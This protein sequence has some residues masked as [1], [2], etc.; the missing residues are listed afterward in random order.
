MERLDAAK[1]SICIGIYDFTA[2]YIRDALIGAM[3]RGVVVELMLDLSGAKEQILFDS[4]TELGAATLRAPSCDSPRAKYF[5]VVHQ[6][7]IVID[8][9]WVLVQ[10]GNYSDNSIPINDPAANW[11][12]FKTGNRDTGIAIESKKIAAFFAK[13]LAADRK[14]VIDA[15][16]APKAIASLKAMRQD[17]A[18]F[19]AKPKKAPTTKFKP[20][21]FAAKNVVV[22]PVLT[23]DNYLPTMEALL[24]GATRSVRI[25]QQ[26]IWSWQSK[27]QVLIQALARAQAKHPKLV[28][29][30]V[31]GKAFKDEDEKK[32]DKALDRLQQDLGLNRTEHVRFINQ[33]MFTHCHNKMILID[34]AIAVIS[35]QN[36]SDTAVD[37]NREAGL[38][39]YD[40][41]VCGYFRKLFDHDF[42]HGVSKP[43]KGKSKFYAAKSFSSG[44][45]VRMDL[46]DIA[47]V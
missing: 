4:L 15:K 40:K 19:L 47:F 46:G 9:Q 39:V 33:D 24:E 35:S 29:E 11:P 3:E 30:I 27:V 8:G 32:F 17:G 6:K 44:Q 31:L 14:L 18:L 13:R 23:P 45:L 34:D 37:T 38:I 21:A 25:E 36:W 10:S 41:A 22:Q 5:P 7:V 26:Y 1:K 12:K 28:I 20:E 43:L 2:N 42:K 16:L